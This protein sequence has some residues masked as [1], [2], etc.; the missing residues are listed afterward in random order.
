MRCADE[1]EV[2][3]QIA[4]ADPENLHRPDKWPLLA[5][6]QQQ[7]RERGDVQSAEEQSSRDSDRKEIWKSFDEKFR[8]YESNKQR[9]C[10]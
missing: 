2:A 8:L 4:L 3:G 1:V 9:K 10:R 7:R 6:L 5:R